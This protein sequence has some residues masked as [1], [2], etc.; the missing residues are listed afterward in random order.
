MVTVAQAGA[1][2]A[3]MP[4]YDSLSLRDRAAAA[5]AALRGRFLQLRRWY[6]L[7]SSCS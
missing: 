7:A 1:T 4:Y 6:A 3:Y 2:G 5:A